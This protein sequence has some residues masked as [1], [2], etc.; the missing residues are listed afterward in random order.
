MENNGLKEF[1][2]KD[3]IKKSVDMKKYIEELL[4]AL[5]ADKDVYESLKPLGLTNKEVRDNIGKLAD[6]QEDFNICKKCPGFDKCP[7]Q[8]PHISTYVYKDGSYLTTRSEP[9]KKLI[10]EM[11]LDSKYLAKDFPQEWKK[12]VVKN[13]DLSENRRPLIKDFINIIKGKSHKWLY[14]KGN[15]KV[16]KS[17]VL[18][19]FAN[20][21]VAMDLGQV[22]VINASK[23]F[24]R[25][26][27][28]AYSDKEGFSKAIQTLST[29]PLLVIDDFGQEYK[30]ELIRDQIVIPILNE[31]VHNDKLTFFSS[32]FTISEIQQLYSIGRNGGALRGKQLGNLLADMC[33]KEYDLTGA[34]IYRKRN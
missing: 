32:E 18:V 25:L 13:L 7:K 11:E 9:C 19:T 33:E 1:D 4:E 5:K 22:A 12:S 23:Q 15:H 3:I 30:N 2:S 24:K 27:D 20:E 29:V 34:S 31:R 6:Y 10:E 28:I 21:F 14:V 17:F 8:T 16:G 26:A